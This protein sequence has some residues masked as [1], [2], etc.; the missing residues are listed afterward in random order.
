MSVQGN[1]YQ[2]VIVGCGLS[3]IAAAVKLKSNG[4][5]NFIILEKGDRVG[6]TWRDNTYPG[7]GC[8]VPSNLYSYSFSPNANW[9]HTYAA[10]PE[11]L[12]YIERTVKEM[13]LLSYIEMQ[14]ELLET[15][16]NKTKRRW[17][18]E[19][20]KGTV[21]S[22]FII[23]AA[24]PIT[25]PSI[26]ELPGAESFA[27]ECFHS[28]RWNH[29]YDLTGKNVAVVGTGASAIQFIPEIQGQVKNL[30][31][32]QR[33]APWVFPKP[34]R[35]ISTVEKWL[36]KRTSILQ[37]ME[38][39]SVEK[40]ML[41]V[42]YGLLHPWLMRA[43]EPAAKAMLRR[44]VPDRTLRKQVTPDFTIGCK[45]VLFSNNYYSTLQKQNVELLPEAVKMLDKSSIVSATGE[46]REVDAVI[47]G[48]G[49][50]VTH[51]PIASRIRT[52]DGGL[53]S[54]SWWD[55]G[56]E[57]YLG[58]TFHDLPNAFFMVGPNILV[59]SSFIGIAEWQTNYIVDAIKTAEENNIEV[60]NL[61]ASIA[62]TYNRT[63]Q[64]ELQGTVWTS[65]NCVSYYLDDNGKNFASWPW[66]IPEL[67]EKLSRFDID[68]YELT[69]GQS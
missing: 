28:A 31:V 40:I 35:K 12:A 68:N 38:R 39:L 14:T 3:G 49:F 50:D 54:D 56:P 42:N 22:K 2:V 61:P 13:N 5:T 16:W 48:T 4:I 7:C 27:G 24:G 67:K 65:G 59:Y 10:Q 46:R 6:G 17:V 25:E 43:F 8:D 58:T 57:A 62:K 32:F 33:T 11:I 15:G 69:Y 53:L 45:R 52:V 64:N 47:L 66:T 37:N 55:N 1:D 9:N 34:N 41:V 51:P 18:V 60:I 26:P 29:D 20:N 36:N 30:Y 23:F 44:S 21:S 19:T 63:V